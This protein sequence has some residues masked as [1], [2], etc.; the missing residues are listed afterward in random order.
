MLQ[1]GGR[2]RN[3]LSD[4]LLFFKTYVSIVHLC[5]WKTNLLHVLKITTEDSIVTCLYFHLGLTHLLSESQQMQDPSTQIFASFLESH[6][7]HTL[8]PMWAGDHSSLAARGP[9]NTGTS[10]RYLKYNKKIRLF[11]LRKDWLSR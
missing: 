5:H 6:K 7:P 8:L 9:G 10:L 3:F 4:G 11:D 2:V 1:L